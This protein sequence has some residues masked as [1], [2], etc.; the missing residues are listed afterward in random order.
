MLMKKE[1]EERQKIISDVV[2]NLTIAMPQ[3]KHYYRGHLVT[4]FKI[5]NDD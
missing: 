2:Y 1:A 3:D 5:K 4:K